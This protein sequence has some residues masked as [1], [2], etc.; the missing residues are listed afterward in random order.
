MDREQDNI[1]PSCEKASR[2]VRASDVRYRYEPLRN[3]SSVLHVTLQLLLAAA[4]HT[5]YPGRPGDGDRG[6]GPGDGVSEELGFGLFAGV[7]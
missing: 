7:R 2:C 5:R 1:H 6:R 4:T 3:R